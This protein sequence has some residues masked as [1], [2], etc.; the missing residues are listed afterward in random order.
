M[1][2]NIITQN[3]AAVNPDSVYFIVDA[4]T[5]LTQLIDGVYPYNGGED[6]WIIVIDCQPTGWARD[7]GAAVV[8]EIET[9]RVR[10]EHAE[11]GNIP[12]DGSV[13]DEPLYYDDEE[14][15]FS[16]SADLYSLN[17]VTL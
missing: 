16:S 3:E 9:L 5:D 1:I 6:H 11:A 17:E 13:S 15:L 10:R 2:K 12:F 14:L 8:Q 7:W 4:E